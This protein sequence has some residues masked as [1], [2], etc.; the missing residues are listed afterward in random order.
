MIAG[1]EHTVAFGR[2]QIGLEFSFQAGL[3]RKTRHEVKNLPTLKPG[4]PERGKI[5]IRHFVKFSNMAEKIAEGLDK[6]GLKFKLP[7]PRKTQL[8]NMRNQVFAEM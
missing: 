6:A 1:K 2:L 3:A 8:P 7:T 4:F 5:L